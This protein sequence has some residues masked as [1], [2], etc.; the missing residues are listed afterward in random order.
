MDRHFTMHNIWNLA[1]GAVLVL[2]FWAILYPQYTLAS[3]AYIKIENGTI[4]TDC[5]NRTDFYNI[6]DAEQG[7]VS[8]RFSF[9]ENPAATKEDT[10]KDKSGKSGKKADMPPAAAEMRDACQKIL[11]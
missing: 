8:I 10:G 1:A 4:Q 5:D 9:L 3:D 11:K 2:S 7:E 6:M